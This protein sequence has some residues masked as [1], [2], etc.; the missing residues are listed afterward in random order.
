MVRAWFDDHHARPPRRRALTHRPAGCNNSNGRGTPP[1][2]SHL[3]AITQNKIVSKASGRSASSILPLALTDVP[4]WNQGVSGRRSLL[5][6]QTKLPLDLMNLL[7]I[8]I[9]SDLICPWC[10]IGRRRLGEALKR[11]EFSEPLSIVWRPFELNPN[12][13]N[14]GLDRKAYRIAKFGSWERSQAMDREVTET[15]KALGMAFDYDRVLVTPNTLNGHRLLWWARETGSQDSL[16]EALFRAYFSEGRDVGKL[17]VLADI[18]AEVGLSREQARR[19]LESDGGREEVLAE[20]R[21]ARRRGLN[22][23]PFFLFNAIPAFA[24]AQPPDVFVEAFRQVLGAK[25]K[26]HDSGLGS[27]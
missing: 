23:V 11:L 22:S 17:E 1:A 2:R 20:E 15:G 12:L 8:D 10:Y 3:I 9:Y 4:R 7:I 18:A 16:A 24:G 6:S 21:E 5:I 27:V 26:A 14:S 13:P 25:V 19:F